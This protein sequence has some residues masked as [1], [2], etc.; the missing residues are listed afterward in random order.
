MTNIRFAKLF[1]AINCALPGLLLGWDAYQHQLGANPVNEAIKTTGLM[2]VVFLTLSLM[3][4]PVRKL[5]G[6][7]SLIHY[8]RALGLAAFFYALGHF[9]IYFIFDRSGSIS[10]TFKEILA[11]PYLMLGAA[12]LLAMLPLAITST[13]AMIKALGAKRWN[14]LH[15]LTYL[16][17]VAGTIHYYLQAK[18]DKRQPTVFIVI[19][20]ILLAYRGIARFFR[21]T[22]ALKSASPSR[23]N[24]D[25]SAM[26]RPM[27]DGTA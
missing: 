23:Q 7:S 1:V 15:R 9:S 21:A 4:T 10:S 3:I 6:W 25:A 22:P 18:S 20:V 14:A 13:N 19:A 8:R 24:P 5:T 2:A 27:K 17:I 11:R 16:A 26:A 12:A